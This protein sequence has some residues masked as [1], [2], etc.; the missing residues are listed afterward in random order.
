MT[1]GI[2]CIENTINNKKYIGKSKNINNRFR[3]HKRKL[4]NNIHE[5]S[6]LQNSWNKYGS[7]C[8]LFY[9]IEECDE[10]VLSEKE[11]SYIIHFNSKN[12]G[13][14][15]T[16]GG[17]GVLNPC[18]ET[19]KRMSDAQ[20]G[21]KVSSETKALLSIVHKNIS[22]ETRQKMRDAKAKM[23]EDTRRKISEA[24][25]GR[26][27]WNKGLETPLEVRERIS[28]SVKKSITQEQREKNRQIATNM[29][30]NAEYKKKMSESLKKYWEN[31]H[32]LSILYKD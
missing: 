26:T 32:N 19:R 25:K 16:D 23:S 8:F 14:N 5:N 15:L 28:Q 7:D 12:N 31:K 22:N 27:P 21:K 17:E 9:V 20:K 24:G 3:Y 10:L 11:K 4:K 13:Y 6:H 18:S 30:R 1:A 2:Y 29:V